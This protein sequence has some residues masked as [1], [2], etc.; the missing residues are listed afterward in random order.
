VKDEG[1]KYGK[2]SKEELEDW[3]IGQ[4]NVSFLEKRGVCCPFMA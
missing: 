4:I 3:G 1:R 2:R